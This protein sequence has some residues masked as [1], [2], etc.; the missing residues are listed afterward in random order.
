MGIGCGVQ[1]QMMKVMQKTLLVRNPA[2][3]EILHFKIA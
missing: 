1:I 3:I 2:N